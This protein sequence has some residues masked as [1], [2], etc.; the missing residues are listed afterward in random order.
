MKSKLCMLLCAALAIVLAADCAWAAQARNNARN[1][2]NARQAAAAKSADDEE[3]TEQEKLEAMPLSE[4]R[5]YQSYVYVPGGRDPMT[6][7]GTS[8]FASDMASTQTTARDLEGITSPEEILSVLDLRLDEIA[9]Y[10]R[11]RDFESVDKVA[12]NAL[13]AS[14][15]DWAGVPG[16]EEKVARLREYQAVANRVLARQDAERRWSALNLNIQGITYSALQSK[17]FVDGV[18]YSSGEYLDAN[19]T[20][21]LES[22]DESGIV[23]ILNGYKFYVPAR[24]FASSKNGHIINALSDS[25]VDSAFKEYNRNI[26]YDSASVKSHRQSTG[27]DMQHRVRELSSGKK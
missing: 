13:N 12:Q 10:A 17:V 1:N 21:R 24:V 8:Q 14:E 20:A 23:V 25:S 4:L 3:L 27:R 5:K 11:I 18:G 2:R 15:S 7:Y 16:L 22:V 19:N 6:M 9:F 26:F